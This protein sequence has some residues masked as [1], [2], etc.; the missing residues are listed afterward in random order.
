M[1]FRELRSWL[2]ISERWKNPQFFNGSRFS[3]HSRIEAYDCGFL[4]LPGFLACLE[5]DE[6]WA[7]VG[8]K[9]RP[10]D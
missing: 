4:I 3:F 2:F 8:V 1:I 9:L 5:V 6:L 10:S 7:V